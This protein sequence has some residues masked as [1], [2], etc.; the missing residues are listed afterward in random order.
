MNT[1]TEAG[2]IAALA[3]ATADGRVVDDPET[4]RRWLVVGEN[5][6]A[7][8][9]SDAHDLKPSPRRI[10]QAVTVQTLDSL[11]DYVMAFRSDE[12]V[13]FA[14]IERNRI[15][16]ALDYHG[17]ALPSNV[18][19]KATMDLP[20]SVEW[21]AWT[22]IDGKMMEQLEFA[23]FLEENA[24][25]IVAPDGAELLEICRDLQARRKVNFI[26]AVRTSSD[27]ENFEYQDETQATTRKGEIEIPTKFEIEIPVYFDGRSIRFFAFLRWR[28]EEGVGLKLG[29][30]LHRAEH[31]RQAVF[32]EIVGQVRE[33]TDRM[34]VFGR[35]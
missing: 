6:R 9:V 16:A 33:R 4:G 31:V 20:F 7:E 35:I 30:A 10:A 19:H 27:N 13:L 29:V 32:K 25:D 23:R 14:D 15:V 12:T 2:Q 34:A 21:A 17:P 18:D 8:E 1:D 24:N 26:K 28:L 3:L 11:V 22:K 5:A